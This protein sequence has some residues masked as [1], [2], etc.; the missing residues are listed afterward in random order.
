MG[1][2]TAR[3]YSTYQDEASL[4]PSIDTSQVSKQSNRSAKSRLSKS[5]KAIVPH[6]SVRI[7]P[8]Q[9][10]ESEKIATQIIYRAREKV[11]GENH[12]TSKKHLSK[13]EYRLLRR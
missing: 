1:G 12:S 11:K 5:P 9:L 8:Q 6:N 2:T 7:N 10:S 4:A 13:A 3:T